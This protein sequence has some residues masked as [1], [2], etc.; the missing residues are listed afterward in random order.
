[1]A[2]MGENTMY[3]EAQNTK[4]IEDIGNSYT[5]FKD[6]DVLVAKVAPCFENG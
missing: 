5:Y 3:F 2:D 4:R 6:D 1:M